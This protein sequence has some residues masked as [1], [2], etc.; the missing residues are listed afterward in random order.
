MIHFKFGLLRVDWDWEDF[1]GFVTVGVIGFAAVA[2][3]VGIF[4]KQVFP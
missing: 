1:C 2:L 4:I 3:T